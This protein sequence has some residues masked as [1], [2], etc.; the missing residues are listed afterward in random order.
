MTGNYWS[1]AIICSPV[2]TSEQTTKI[3]ET[4][5]T[6]IG[7]TAVSKP[8]WV[9]F[10]SKNTGCGKF[11]SWKKSFFISYLGFFHQNHP[12]TKTWNTLKQAETT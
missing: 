5:F 1:P 11:E 4:G 3:S 9:G 6:K 2:G 8:Q 12:H 10:S 7:H